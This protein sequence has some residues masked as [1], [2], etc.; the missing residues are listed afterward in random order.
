MCEVKHRERMGVLREPW[1]HHDIIRIVA[2]FV[3]RGHVLDLDASSR[4]ERRLVFRSRLHSGA[5]EGA[6]LTEHLSIQSP[7]HGTYRM[8]RDLRLRNG[9]A[10]RIVALG[11]D[12]SELMHEIEQV[13]PERGFLLGERFVLAKEHN[14]ELFQPSSSSGSRRGKPIFKRAVAQ[15]S[16]LTLTVTMPDVSGFP[17]KMRIV[18]AAGGPLELPHDLL[19]VIGA[20]WRP[21][22]RVDGAWQTT[23]A[24][25][26]REPG[27]SQRAEA[28]VEHA[29]AHI[30]RTLVEPPHRFHAQRPG[31]RWMAELRR[32]GPSMFW[33]AICLAVIWLASE[34]RSPVA[35]ALAMSPVAGFLCFG[36]RFLD[37]CRISVPRCP[38]PPPP[39][40][41]PHPRHDG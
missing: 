29:V 24:V 34:P 1:T 20:Q 32:A 38:R 6:C 18:A 30:A 2:P 16:E 3:E 41:W 11:P 28:S 37:W 17:A 23:L 15:V 25:R 21:L 13:P 14:I 26:G 27:Q 35:I 7:W 8:V 33:V 31:A 40:A 9:L 10:S 39:G 5:I 22:E 4:N 12:P 19:S 36:V